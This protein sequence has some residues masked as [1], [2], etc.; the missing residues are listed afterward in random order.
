MGREL[1]ADLLTIIFKYLCPADF[2]SCR[3]VNKFWKA[4]CDD[5][6]ITNHRLQRACSIF[7]DGA[8]DSEEIVRKGSHCSIPRGGMIGQ[9]QCS[10]ILAFCQNRVAIG[11]KG[12]RSSFYP[13]L[14]GDPNPDPGIFHGFCCDKD[15]VVYAI[16]LRSIWRLAESKYAERIFLGA[17]G[18]N[19]RV[20]CV[21]T[22]LVVSTTSGVEALKGNDW[23]TLAT[24]TQHTGLFPNL[25][26]VSPLSNHDPEANKGA[27][28]VFTHRGCAHTSCLLHIIDSTPKVIASR[29]LGMASREFCNVAISRDGS[30]VCVET[31]ANNESAM[32]VYHVT[33]G[34]DVYRSSINEV[35]SFRCN[36][37]SKGPCKDVVI[38]GDYIIVVEAS[39]RMKAWWRETCAFEW[40]HEGAKDLKK[41]SLVDAIAVSEDKVAFLSSRRVHV[42]SV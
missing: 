9:C 22:T 2:C 25:G 28:L 41:Q 16:G 5:I 11:V 12:A 26:V 27:M 29:N 17:P 23:I 39:G 13:W 42:F 19:A 8:P 34:T 40:E 6:Y 32:T 35:G 30:T 37:K 4:V 15:G 20:M 38:N 18:S 33:Y 7:Y 10:G 14:L 31:F 24:N 36:Y 21:G 3:G 1:S